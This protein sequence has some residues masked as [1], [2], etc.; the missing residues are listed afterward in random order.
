MSKTVDK[1]GPPQFTDVTYTIV[2]RNNGPVG[3]LTEAVYTGNTAAFVPNTVVI[4]DT[5][6]VGLTF[7]S[8]DTGGS[9]GWRRRCLER[10]R[11]ASKAHEITLRFTAKVAAAPGTTVVNRVHRSNGPADTTRLRPCLT[12]TPA[13]NA[14]AR[15]SRSFTTNHL[16]V[17]GCNKST[18]RN[19]T[20]GQQVT[21]TV[22]YSDP[23][24]L[25]SAHIDVLTGVMVSRWNLAGAADT[26]ARRRISSYT[27]MRTTTTADR[28]LHDFGKGYR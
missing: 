1:A 14:P 15:Q 7:V 20:E 25:D 5:L 2:V 12:P 16:H 17:S 21:L 27:H 23:D 13:N 22:R 4:R 28:Q 9:I 10:A 26:Q 8:A 11:L 19:I 18:I 6:P 3:P 24:V